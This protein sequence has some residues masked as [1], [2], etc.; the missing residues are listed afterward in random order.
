M[1]GLKDMAGMMKQAQ[2]MKKDMEAMQGELGDVV[3]QGSAGGGM[4]TVEMSGKMEV[5][6][7]KISP[8]AVDPEDIE[9]LEDLAAA[10]FNDAQTK[11][12]SHVNERVNAITGGMSIPGLT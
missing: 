1:K 8:D 5:R 4:V 2:Q 7:V 9:T 6:S 10:A 3:L 12:Q 11:V